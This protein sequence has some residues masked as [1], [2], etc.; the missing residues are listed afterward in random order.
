MFQ[1]KTSS[2]SP[3][4]TPASSILASDLYCTEPEQRLVTVLFITSCM[5]QIAWKQWLLPTETVQF[6]YWCHNGRADSGTSA[7]FAIGKYKNYRTLSFLLVL[8]IL[9]CS[10][11]LVFVAYLMALHNMSFYHLTF[12]LEHSYSH[13]K[14]LCWLGFTYVFADIFL[15]LEKYLLHI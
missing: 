7:D 5:S 6:V 2:G 14:R 11:L 1:N 12:S 4:F 13:L 9:F 10:W 15:D 3:F 8:Y